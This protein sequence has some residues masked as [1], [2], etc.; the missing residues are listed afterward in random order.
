VYACCGL[1]A[2]TDRDGVATEYYYDAAQRQ[3]ASARLGITITNVLDGAGRA[4]QST[5]IGTDASAIQLSGA[6]YGND[7]SLLWE[8]NGLFGVTS[9][10]QTT[11]T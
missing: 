9:H 11:N 6:G 7:G 2:A 4:L 1:S 10:V 3:T 8:T 5:R